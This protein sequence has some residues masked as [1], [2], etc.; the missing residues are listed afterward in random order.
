M[1]VGTI[2]NGG[3]TVFDPATGTSDHI[4]T[5]DFMTT[6]IAFGG[7]DDRD[8][9]ITAAGTGRVLKGRWPRPGLPLAFSA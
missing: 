6:N 3:I 2:V 7:A 9:W 8:V 5:G 4:A 1:C